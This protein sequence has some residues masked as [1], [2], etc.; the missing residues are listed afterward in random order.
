MHAASTIEERVKHIANRQYGTREDDIGRDSVL[1]SGLEGDALD[2]VEIL[3]ALEQEFQCKIP[4]EDAL[5]L[6]TCGDI[7]DY[8]SRMLP[9]GDG[10]IAYDIEQTAH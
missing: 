4:D 3:L 9:P 7:V 6:H 1:L 8:L 10:A 2:G 5:K